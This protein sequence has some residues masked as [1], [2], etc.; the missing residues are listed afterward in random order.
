MRL[1]AIKRLEQNRFNGNQMYPLFNPLACQKIDEYGQ[2][3][4]YQFQ[5]AMNG[6][7]HFIPDLGYWVDG[8]DKKKNIV[9]EVDEHHHFDIDGNLK[10]K[11]VIRQKEITSLLKCKFIRLII[12]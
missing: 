10:E 5:H 2:Q 7:E 4:G 11:D 8:Y 12:S 6:G 9:I 1:K 3:N